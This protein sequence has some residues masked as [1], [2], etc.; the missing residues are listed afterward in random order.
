VPVSSDHWDAS[1]W[2]IIVLCIVVFC[3]GC[4]GKAVSGN[5]R[6]GRPAT[7]VNTAGY[8]NGQYY[9][10][11]PSYGNDFGGGGGGGGGDFGGGG[12]GI[13]SYTPTY[14]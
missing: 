2:I 10:S 3:G 11:G 6:G 9:D 13:D 8:G 7:V 5:R 4:F 14:A 1:D 12:G